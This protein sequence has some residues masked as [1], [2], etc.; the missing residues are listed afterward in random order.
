VRHFC[1]LTS[2]ALLALTAACPIA[3]PSVPL[4]YFDFRARLQAAISDT[5]VVEMEGLPM[6]RDSLEAR[7]PDLA[8]IL[9]VDSL[10]AALDASP[11]LSPLAGAAATTVRI[12]L[13]SKSVG[14]SVRRAFRNADGQRQAVDAMVIGLGRAVH[15][16]RSSE[17]RRY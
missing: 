5:A 10:V 3:R 6:M 7:L 15:L 13:E 1:L 2:C 9:T 4:E 16:L 17:Q 11:T 8:A 14:G 12:T